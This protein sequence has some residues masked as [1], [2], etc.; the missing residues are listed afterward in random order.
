M[1]LYQDTL[2]SADG[3]S[4]VNL[5][6]AAGTGITST[7]T[8][9]RQALDVNI[10][11]GSSSAAVADKTTYTYGTTL[12]QNFGG[13]FQDTSPALTAGQSGA[14]RLTANRGVHSNL[15][16]AAGVELLG[17]QVSAASI[18]VVIAS[19]Q[20]AVSVVDAA[21]GSVT[22]GTA[23]TKSMLGGLIFNTALPTLTNGQQAALQGDSS[24]RLITNDT[25]GASISAKMSPATSTLTQLALTTASQTVLASNT[26][27]KG[28]IIVND[29][30]GTVKIGFVSAVTGTAYTYKMQPNTILEILESRV[31]TG[32]ITALSSLAAG[33]LVIT[34]LT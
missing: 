11:G 33:N 22:G 6:D 34:E 25:N 12:F 3:G 29:S 23:G 15:R 14:L 21:D 30:L 7:L 18:P 1:G 17:S 32:I 31:Y 20:G 4:F 16:T 26:A 13:V 5:R 9:G 19:D 28:A 27:R 8:G 24:G 10:A 2:E